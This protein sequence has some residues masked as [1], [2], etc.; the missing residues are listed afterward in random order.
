MHCMVF[1]EALEDLGDF[2]GAGCIFHFEKCDVFG[3]P[4]MKINADSSNTSNIDSRWHSGVNL[5]V[6]LIVTIG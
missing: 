6:S 1:L 4:P 3:G 2:R 5:Y